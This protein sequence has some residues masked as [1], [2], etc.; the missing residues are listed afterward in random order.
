VAGAEH[1]LN[2]DFGARPAEALSRARDSALTFRRIGAETREATAVI[3][4]AAYELALGRVDD[5][6]AT[7]REGLGLALRTDDPRLAVTAMQHLAVVA[8]ARRNNRRAAQLIGYVDA[9]CKHEGYERDR[10]ERPTSA[11]DDPSGIADLAESAP[12]LRCDLG[13]IVLVDLRQESL[14]PTS[15]VGLQA[16]FAPSRRASPAIWAPRRDKLAEVWDHVRATRMLA[17]SGR[18]SLRYCSNDTAEAALREP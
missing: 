16:A 7:A 10:S 4:A 11:F 17:T 8:N 2:D 15:S 6:A 14:N 12:Q 5:A 3:N 18:V 9:W 1:C 13:V